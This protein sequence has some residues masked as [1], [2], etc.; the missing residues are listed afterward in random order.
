MCCNA[1]SSTR[2]RRPSGGRVTARETP[3]ARAVGSTNRAAAVTTAA[4]S[5][6]SPGEPWPR[7]M[8]RKCC[9]MARQRS[10]WSRA[11]AAL[12]ATWSRVS[13][14]SGG[15]P[16][17]LRMLSTQVSTV[18][19]GVF[20]S[21]EKPDASRPSDASR[22]DSAMDA[23][24]AR[25]F[26]MSRQ[27][28]T[29]WVTL[30]SGPGIGDAWISSHRTSPFGAERSQRR[31]WRSPVRMQAEVGHCATS[32]P[33]MPV[34]RQQ[35]PRTVSRW[36][37]VLARN[38]SFAAITWREP[39]ST[40]IPSSMLLMTVSSRSRWFRTSSTRPVTESAIALNSRAS[41]E[42]VSEPSAGTRRSRSPDAICRAVISKRC[43]RRRMANRRMAAM[44]PTSTSVA[45]P[46]APTIQP[47]SR[48][49]D[50]RTELTLRSRMRIPLMRRA[51][52][53]TRGIAP[54]CGTARRSGARCRRRSR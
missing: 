4:G 14:P 28:S 25:R 40:T 2:T 19:S 18:A 37:P 51:G 46:V 52:R 9:V 31:T 7:A 39:S 10:T 3:D 22:C 12:S 15:R 8:R 42:M 53:G 44:A 33:A 36:P 34:S 20:S 49:I 16:T 17:S 5:T 6:T 30:P 11:M 23:S 45:A 47:R 50:A 43:R 32:Q 26:V 1:A 54:G 41:Q 27:T 29:T 21:C 35:H 48:S 24:A 38:A 13:P